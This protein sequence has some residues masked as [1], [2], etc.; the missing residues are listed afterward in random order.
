MFH[1]V[2]L[3]PSFTRF[4]TS[5]CVECVQL[6]HVFHQALCKGLAEC[7][8]DLRTLQWLAMVPCKRARGKTPEAM[9]VKTPDAKT[10]QKAES[11]LK[12][13]QRKKKSNKS[14]TDDKVRRKLSFAE[15]VEV[16]SIQ[17]EHAAPS[18]SASSKARKGKV[19][20]EEEADKILA[21]VPVPVSAVPTL[22]V[23][24]SIYIYIY[25]AYPR[26]ICLRQS[27]LMH[28]LLRVMSTMMMRRLV[29][30]M[31]SDLFHSH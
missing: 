26:C 22:C 2:E 27:L 4:N 14:P 6:I 20:T 31:F 19:M 24:V 1:C 9:L 7:H 25:S 17:A 3:M 18:T 28:R 30:V 12:G 10:L 29:R 15:Q 11:I 5:V 13:K 21:S 8:G 16:H 23:S